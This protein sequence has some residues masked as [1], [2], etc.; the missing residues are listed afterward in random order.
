MMHNPDS[1]KNAEHYKRFEKDK[2]DQNYGSGANPGLPWKYIGII[3]GA[4]VAF[5]VAIIIF[6]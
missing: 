2:L 4:I 6:V 3:V 5:I 1:Q